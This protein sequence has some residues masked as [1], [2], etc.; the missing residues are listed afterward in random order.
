[1]ARTPPIVTEWNRPRY[2]SVTELQDVSWVQ[3][4]DVNW[5]D[6]FVIWA[7]WAGDLVL[8]ISTTWI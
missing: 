8:R 2:V 6:I 3:I 4:Q 5:D 1:M 7:G